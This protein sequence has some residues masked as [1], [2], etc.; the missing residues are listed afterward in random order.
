MGLDALA[1]VTGGRRLRPTSL[2]GKL[3][4]WQSF[5]GGRDEFKLWREILAAV[6]NE[7]KRNK[8]RYKANFVYKSH[9]SRPGNRRLLTEQL[10]TKS[11]LLILHRNG[12]TIAASTLLSR[13]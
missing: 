12:A 3:Y 4:S 9:Q 7:N 10:T 2:S 5:C 13:R 11:N 8:P 1:V 6:I